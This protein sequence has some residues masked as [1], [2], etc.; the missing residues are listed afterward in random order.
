MFRED[1]ARQEDLK[2]TFE[3]LKAA[4]LGEIDFCRA[5]S[6]ETESNSKLNKKG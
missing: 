4:I 6:E 5:V 2:N 1:V 3:A